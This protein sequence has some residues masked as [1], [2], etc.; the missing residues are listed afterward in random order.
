[1]SVW[2]YV[3]MSNHLDVVVEMHP[4]IAAEW[5]SETVAERWLGLY[6]P[7]DGQYEAAKAMM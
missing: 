6:P 5:S 3:V 2:A 7:E 1:M 4:D